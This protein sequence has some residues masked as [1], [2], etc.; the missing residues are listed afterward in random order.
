MVAVKAIKYAE[1]IWNTYRDLPN[2]ASL[3]R[4]GRAR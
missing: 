1:Q 4:Y 2:A 3:R